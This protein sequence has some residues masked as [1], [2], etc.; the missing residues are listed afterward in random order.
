LLWRCF[1]CRK[2]WAIAKTTALAS[3]RISGCPLTDTCACFHAAAPKHDRPLH[4][5]AQV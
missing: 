2:C 1:S 5:L 3:D 4:R